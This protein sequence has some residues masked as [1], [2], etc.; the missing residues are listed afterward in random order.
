MRRPCRALAWSADGSLLALGHVDS[1]TLRKGGVRVVDAS[2]RAVVTTLDTGGSPTFSLA[3]GGADTV[4]GA[5]GRELRNLR[6]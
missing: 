2:T 1:D 3:F 6:L 5:F 4:V